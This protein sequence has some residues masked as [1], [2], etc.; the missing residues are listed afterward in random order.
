MMSAGSA[1]AEAQEEKVPTRIV[2]ADSL[3]DIDELNAIIAA[4]GSHED[5]AE[6]SE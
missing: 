1:R 6:V 4:H 3:K 2:E 5:G